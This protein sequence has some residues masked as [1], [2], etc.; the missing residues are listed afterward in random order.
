MQSKIAHPLAEK[1]Y[2]P[3]RRRTQRRREKNEDKKSGRAQKRPPKT[4][5][6]VFLTVLKRRVFCKTVYLR[7]TSLRSAKPCGA[8]LCRLFI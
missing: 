7:K 4:V 8:W 5:K 2:T 3:G 6:K 1:Y